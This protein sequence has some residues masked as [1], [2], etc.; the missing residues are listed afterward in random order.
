[1]TNPKAQALKNLIENKNRSMARTRSKDISYREKKMV[2]DKKYSQR[3]YKATHHERRKERRDFERYL[4]GKP[5][6]LSHNR[7]GEIIK[8]D[9]E[10]IRE[11]RHPDDR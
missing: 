8:E 10:R 1:M 6:S 2:G 5:H 9:D 3:V 11:T 7:V 4:E